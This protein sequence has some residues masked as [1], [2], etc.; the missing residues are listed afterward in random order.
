MILS[1]GEFEHIGVYVS[2]CVELHSDCQLILLHAGL[3]CYGIDEPG[4][5]S[6][7]EP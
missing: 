7:L 4:G 2:W 6:S 3:I 5:Y 1:Y